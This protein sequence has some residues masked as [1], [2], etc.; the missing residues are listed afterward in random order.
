[1][2]P[3]SITINVR[4]YRS[5]WKQWLVVL[6]FRIPQAGPIIAGWL[7][8]RL[9]PLS[10]KVGNRKRRCVTWDEVLRGGKSCEE[11]DT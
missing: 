8:E 10:I 5:A 3:E 9:H 6:S 7:W 11:Q 2:P 1:M 4:T